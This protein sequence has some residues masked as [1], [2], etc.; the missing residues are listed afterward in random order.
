MMCAL[1]CIKRLKAQVALAG[2]DLLYSTDGDN[3]IEDTTTLFTLRA[4]NIS[5][6]KQTNFKIILR[7][8]PF[9]SNEQ[10]PLNVLAEKFSEAK[11]RL[12][13]TGLFHH[14]VVSLSSLRGYEA[15]VNVEVKERWYIM[16]IPFVKA[17]DRSI[18]E[19]VQEQNMDLERVNYGIKIK[20]NNIS[21][22]NDKLYVNLKN[23]YTKE[24]SLAYYGLML[25]KDLKWSTSLGISLGKNKEVNYNTEGNKLLAFKNDNN[26]FV[27]SYLRTFFEVTYRQAIN[28]RHTFGVS[29]NSEDVADTILAINSHYFT[30]SSKIRYPSL[31]YTLSYSNTDFIPYPLKGYVAEVSV[32]KR[33]L[34]EN[35]LNL[36]HLTA[37]GSG[38]WPLSKKYFMNLR[39]AG[40]LKLPFKQPYI[41]QQF[42]GY[43][44]MYMQG[45]EYY[46]IDGVA[47]GYSKLSFSRELFNTSINI[48]SQTIRRLNHIPF[49][50]YAKVY[51][52]AGYIYNPQA[53]KN[54]LSNKVIFSGGFG[55]DIVT[56]Y[57]FII[58]LE[59]S[60]NQLG[61]NGL[62]LHRRDYF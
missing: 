60:F 58:K 57:D 6:N 40:C 4:I 1:C 29:Y 61:Q 23:G 42:V 5:G 50:A 56:F 34:G 8:L 49:R 39:M 20:H 30:N 13:N 48:P 7:E 45:Y 38:T 54:P 19:W 24:V 10:Y 21:G 31:Y 3:V 15:S 16:P 2:P 62:Y 47:G 14:V 41:N 28:T 53:G 32:A 26:N 51:G 59:W 12:M 9:Q 52:N 11:R 27:H 18:G 33:G 43:R 25:D 22:R 44:D 37:K 46:V 55:L 35:Q 17:V 36:W